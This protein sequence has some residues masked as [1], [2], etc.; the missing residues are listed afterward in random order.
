[1]PN[2]LIVTTPSYQARLTYS[3]QLGAVTHVA[4]RPIS[5]AYSIAFAFCD[6]SQCL[7]L[8]FVYSLPIAFDIALF[9]TLHDYYLIKTY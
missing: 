2:N 4:W 9:N 5:L 7:E 1:M 6:S 3:A 8:I